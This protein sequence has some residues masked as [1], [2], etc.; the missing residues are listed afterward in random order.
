[1]P[2]YDKT[3]GADKKGSGDR[4]DMSVPDYAYGSHHFRKTERGILIDKGQ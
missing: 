2:F 3:Y 4:E 1:M